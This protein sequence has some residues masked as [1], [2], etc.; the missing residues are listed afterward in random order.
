MNKIKLIMK[1]LPISIMLIMCL[2]NNAESALMVIIDNETY[3]HVD[4]M[5]NTLQVMK[6]GNVI[7]RKSFDN[8]I[9]SL[10]WSSVKNCLIVD[11]SNLEHETTDCYILSQDLCT[12]KL[13]HAEEQVSALT[14]DEN[15]LY[16]TGISS[17]V[18]GNVYN[19]PNGEI[20][21]NL[22]PEQTRCRYYFAHIENN[23]W[24][25]IF[26]DD[27]TASMELIEITSG[28][29]LW[30]TKTNKFSYSEYFALA[31][32]EC[33]DKNIYMT[34]VNPVD[35]K[36]Q[37][38]VLNKRTGNIVD[39]ICSSSGWGGGSTI[40]LIS[41]F[42]I[43]VILWSNGLCSILDTL[44]NSIFAEELGHDIM[45]PKTFVTVT[46]SENSVQFFS[47]FRRKKSKNAKIEYG[48]IVLTVPIDEAQYEYI[49]GIGALSNK[50]I[51]KSFCNMNGNDHE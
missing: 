46:K 8:P 7:S 44:T 40:G 48:S 21:W 45:L 26:V 30:E 6:S 37:L 2:G 49:S 9:M 33:T 5:Q 23:Q 51:Y 18:D 43:L 4:D 22:S 11:I 41:N 24:I 13:L 29:V 34:T 1:I 17:S 15:Y 50:G 20:L 28:R 47:K 3:A 32:V 39:V 35:Q 14:Q 31:G 25:R 27:I 38:I 42:K 36:P 16:F 10:K 12:I 19:L